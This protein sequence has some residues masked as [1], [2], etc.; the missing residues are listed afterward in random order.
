MKRPIL[1]LLTEGLVYD[2]AHAREG[3]PVCG[4]ALR[5]VWDGDDEFPEA[6]GVWPMLRAEVGCVHRI[7]ASAAGVGFAF[8][9]GR[10][11]GPMPHVFIRS[12]GLN[13]RC[14]FSTSAWAS[15][16]YRLVISSD[17]C[18]SIRIREN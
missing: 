8:P 3:C 16:T 17:S 12:A 10:G 18:P 5:L 7:G 4:S 11:R 6:F 2:L 9:R 13:C 14:C 1:P 15:R